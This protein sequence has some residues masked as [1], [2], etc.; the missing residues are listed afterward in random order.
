VGRPGPQRTRPKCRFSRPAQAAIASTTVPDALFVPDGDRL[1]PTELARGPWSADALHGGPVAAV[2][3]RAVEACGTLV[4]MRVTRLTVELLRPVPLTPLTVTAQ[5]VRPG[6]R[7]QLVEGSVTAG[8]TEVA[9]VRA[10]RIRTAEVPVPVQEPSPRTPTD[11]LAAPQR[12][13]APDAAVRGLAFH[14]D[15]VEMR[16]IA[17]A[18][19]SA[20]A[21]TVWMRLLRPVV[22]G[23]ETSPLQRVAALADFGNGISGIVPFGT[24]TFVNP[25]LTVA[26]ARLPTDEWVGLDAVSRLSHDGVGMAESLLFDRIGPIGRAVQ[27][28]YVDAR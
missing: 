14:A 20:G 5:V 22:A 6:K 9:R 19:E 16:L 27:T 25:D 26:L 13:F 3:A 10:L 24:H 15:A 23:E 2:L 7:V 17:G 21:A 8:D 1:I 28:L 18:F 12:V 11:P 4:P